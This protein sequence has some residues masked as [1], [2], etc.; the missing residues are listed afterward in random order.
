MEKPRI[1]IKSFGCSTNIADGEVIA[2]CLAEAGYSIV[3]GIDQA[4]VVIYNTCAVKGPTE[5][6][7]ISLLK[8]VPSSKKIIVAGCLPLINFDRLVKE[9]RFEGVVGPAPGDKIVHIVDRVVAGE[10]VIALENAQH[11]MPSLLLPRIRVNPII[12]IIPVSY[13]CLGSCAY[14]CV[15]F[16]RGKLRSYPVHEII[17]RIR[18]DLADG[19]KEF[20]ITSQ[21]TA[22][23]GKDIGSSLPKLLESICAVNGVFNVR[24]GMMNPHMALGI[25]KE[26]L[27]AFENDKIFK[28]LHLP[29]Q[30]GDNDVLK[31]MRRPY[32]IAEFKRVVEAFKDKFPRL[33]LAT[34]IICGFPGESREAFENT[35]KLVEEVKPDIVNISKFFARPRTPAAKMD[36]KIPATEI[37]RRSEILTELALKISLERNM[38]WIGWEGEI[39][40]DEIGMVRGS[41]IGRNFAYKPIV[42]KSESNLLGKRLKVR[43]ERAFPTYLEGKIILS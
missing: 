16:A 9:T 30:S 29:V 43:V 5:D 27:K 7:M 39:L 13:G 17:E 10:R 26:L 23:Y 8:H 28:F 32:T 3:G 1:Y 22:C 6:R 36:H 37:K 41:W 14:C 11:S 20:W 2:G 19:V 21:D 38:E 42:V 4:E 24:V 31:L 25:L 15:V 40:V 33:T 35:L 34:D 12:G 18:L